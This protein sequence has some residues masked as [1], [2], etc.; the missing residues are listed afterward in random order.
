M[1]HVALEEMNKLSM[2]RLLES[3]RPIAMSF[4]SWDLYEYSLLQTTTKHTWTVKALSQIEKPRYVIFAMQTDRK[5]NLENSACR[6][7][8]CKLTNVRLFLNSEAYPYDDLN[9]DFNKSKYAL[10]YDMYAKFTRSYY[11]YG[12]PLL[13][14]VEFLRYAPIA[15]ID[16]S[17]QNESVKS[18]TVNVRIDFECRDNVPANTT[19]YCL[20]IHDL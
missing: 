2:L 15:I 17:R 12:E 13:N 11:G 20:L 4:L 14:T 8:A 10:L 7:D 3:D 6:L 9:L 1:P 5:N 18:A 16:Y 19:A